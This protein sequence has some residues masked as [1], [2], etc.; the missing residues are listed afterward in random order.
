M[1]YNISFSCDD[2]IFYLPGIEN[3][4]G[5]NPE[6]MNYAG[7]LPFHYGFDFRL[8]TFSPGYQNGSDGTDRGVFGG[9]GFK[10]TTT[11][12]PSIAVIT[13]FTINEPTVISPGGTLN[14]TVT[15]KRVN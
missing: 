3:Y 8:Q 11:G 13:T 1:S 15:S 10:F 9:L 14:I 6:F 5:F 12:E 2:N 7:S 4:E